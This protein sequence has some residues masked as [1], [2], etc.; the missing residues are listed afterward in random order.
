MYVKYRCIP[1][2]NT[3]Y[4]CKNVELFFKDEYTQVQLYIHDNPMQKCRRLGP[5]RVINAN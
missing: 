5:C 1:A 3:S 4:A 2:Q